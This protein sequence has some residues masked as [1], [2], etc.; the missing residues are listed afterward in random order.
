[1]DLEFSLIEVNTLNRKE[2]PKPDETI[3]DDLEID[4]LVSNIK[5]MNVYFRDKESCPYKRGNWV[6][7]IILIT[8]QLM[9]LKY[10]KEMKRAEFLRFIK[11]LTTALDNYKKSK[12]N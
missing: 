3:E 7:D 2:I 6:I 9:C 4:K 11:P 1:M 10:P 5:E 12:M 8:N